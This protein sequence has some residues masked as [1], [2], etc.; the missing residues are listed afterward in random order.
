[1]RKQFLLAQ[2]KDEDKD[3]TYF[4]HQLTQEQLAHTMFPLGEYTKKEVRKMAEQ[5]DLPT[6]EREESMGICFVGEIPMKEFLQQKI[7][8]TPGNIVTEDGTVIGEHEGLAFYTIGQRHLGLQPRANSQ[9]KDQQ[10][11]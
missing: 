2:A 1:N 6:A 8:K 4:L 11:L 10:P 7:K 9:Q 3:Q 5:F